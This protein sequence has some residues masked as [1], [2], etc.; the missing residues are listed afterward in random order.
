LQTQLIA[1]VDDDALARD[2]I[3]ELVESLGFKAVTFTSAEDFLQ[4]GMI[5]KTTCLITDQQMPGLNGV[6]LQEALRSQGYHTPVIVI[7]AFPNEKLRARA[8]EAGAV[9]FL[10]KPFGEELLI[11]FLSDAITRN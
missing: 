5:A 7:T 2:G 9:G 6:E 10:S 3:C 1:I 4:S 8:L 11:K